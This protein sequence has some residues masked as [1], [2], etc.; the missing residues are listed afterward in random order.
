MRD[1]LDAASNDRERVLISCVGM[2][3]TKPPVSV[4]AKIL[5]VK[6]GSRR[7]RAH[8]TKLFPGILMGTA[9]DMPENRDSDNVPPV[10]F[11]SRKPE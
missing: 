3:A 4:A 8:G 9:R 5:L 11:G 1:R 2:R 6:P 10:P 7:C